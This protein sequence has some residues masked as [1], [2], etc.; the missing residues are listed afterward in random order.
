LT[1]GGATDDPAHPPLPDRLAALQAYP[2]PAMLN[3]DADPATTTLGD[4]ETLEQMLHNRIF[5]LPA[6]EPSVF[7]KTR[8]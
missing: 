4:L 5:G 2:N 1:E 3:G 8:A 7:H 6:I